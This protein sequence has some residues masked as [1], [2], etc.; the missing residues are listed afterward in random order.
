MCLPLLRK[1]IQACLIQIACLIQ[2][3]T[4]TV[5]LHFV[6][7]V[8]SVKYFVICTVFY[9]LYNEVQLLTSLANIWARLFKAWLA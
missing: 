9:R 2:V 6:M 7:K 4:K 3:V 8:E 5:L 1:C